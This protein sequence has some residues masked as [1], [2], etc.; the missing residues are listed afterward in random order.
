MRSAVW[1]DGEAGAAFDAAAGKDFLP[2]PAL[3]AL[4]K[5]MFGFALFFVWLICSFWHNEV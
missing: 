2:C 5:S 3:V 1:L 4:H